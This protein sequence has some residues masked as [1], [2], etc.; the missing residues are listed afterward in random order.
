M[1]QTGTQNP[2]VVTMANKQDKG[3]SPANPENQENLTSQP[4]TTGNGHEE[5]CVGFFLC[6]C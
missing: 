1:G 5:E 3:T 2:H 4:T 6:F